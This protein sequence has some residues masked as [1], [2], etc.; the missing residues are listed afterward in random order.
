MPKL[1]NDTIDAH[2]Q[3]VTEAI[4]EA[5][6]TLSVEGGVT[7]V[8]MSQV[9]ARVGIGRATLYKYFPDIESM[10]IAHHQR[11]VQAH[12]EQLRR[13]SNESGAAAE[14]LE[15]VLTAYGF[16]AH[17]RKDHVT[18]GISA[19]VHQREQIAPAEQQL[20]ELITNVLADAAHEGAI[21]QDIPADELATYSLHAITAAA[22]LPDAAAVRRLVAITLNGLRPG[23]AGQ[24]P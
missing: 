11:H 3:A 22:E 9:A 23:P 12:L 1:W 16:I 24:H 4:L 10:L 15:A 14:R 5:A 20:K 17:H 19:M 2:R 21:R 18:A 7:S 8:T 6:Y 13:L